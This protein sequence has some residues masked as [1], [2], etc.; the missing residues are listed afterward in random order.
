MHEKLY[1]SQD[2]SRVDFANYLHTLVNTTLLAQGGSERNINTR[3]EAQTLR[4][5]V[6]AAIPCGLIANELV[7]HLYKPPSR[8][9]FS[10]C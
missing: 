10:P 2:L 7:T 6:G 1:E 8:T 3:I 4:L 5:P 9:W